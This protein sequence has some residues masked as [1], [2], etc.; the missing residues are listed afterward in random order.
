MDRNVVLTIRGLHAGGETEDG[1]LETVIK[2]EYFKKGGTHYLLYEEE[3]EGFP[4]PLKSRIKYKDRVLELTR[5]G[6]IET[7]IIF[8]QGKKTMSR[9][10]V[11]Y[12]EMTLGVETSEVRMEEWEDSLKIQAEYDLEIDGE[13][14]A[15]SR[16]EIFA[17]EENGTANP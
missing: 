10:A 15:H 16:I 11:P 6:L 9:Y 1:S 13:H 7:H 17:T 3:Q 4:Q 12:G 8:E 5:Q 2:A 14:Q